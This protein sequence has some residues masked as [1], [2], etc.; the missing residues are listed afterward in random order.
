ML[1]HGLVFFTSLDDIVIRSFVLKLGFWQIDGKK[2]PRYCYQP[3]WNNYT[4]TILK[5]NIFFPSQQVKRKIMLLFF[6]NVYFV[7]I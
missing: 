5:K 2:A 1:I 3:I 4:L 7:N 6:F